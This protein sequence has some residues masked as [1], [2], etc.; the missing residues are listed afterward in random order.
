[1]AGNDM[2]RLFYKER[3]NDLLEVA[4]RQ[5][6]HSTIAMTRIYVDVKIFAKSQSR[7]IVHKNEMKVIVG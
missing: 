7:S 2:V 3:A 4:R 6:G 5:M 1:M